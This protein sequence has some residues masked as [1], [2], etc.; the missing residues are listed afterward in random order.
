LN[1]LDWTLIVLIGLLGIRCMIRGF[2][3]EMLSMAALAAGILAALVLYRPAGALFTSWGLSP[4]PAALPDI[5]GF[6]AAF[7]A[8]FLATRLVGRLA[9]EGLESSELGGLDKALGL[10]LGLAEGLLLACLILLGMSLAEPAFASFPGYG[11]LLSGSAFAKVLLPLIGP[12]LAKAV[13]GIKA[14][15]LDLRLQHPAPSAP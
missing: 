11:K 6:I 4:T 10:L 1:G 14:P 8:A 13:Q 7:A 3:A 15:G 12:E 9:S 2:A 5:L